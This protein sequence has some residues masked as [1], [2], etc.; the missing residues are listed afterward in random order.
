MSISL[1]KEKL[2]EVLKGASLAGST[3]EK[4]SF[5]GVEYDSREIKGGE[6]FIAL[7]GGANHGHQF[8]KQAFERGASICLVEDSQAAKNSEF[9]ERCVVVEDTLKA[10]WEL[11]SYWRNELA[12]PVLAVTGSVGKTTIKEMTASL[13]LRR[14]Q[15][16]YS[17]KSHNNQTGVPYTICRAARHHRW[18]VLEMGMNHAGE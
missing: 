7:K 11:A 14:E 17:L 10:F 9:P 18:A 15:G 5:A 4:I 8:V 2:I 3:P 16:V 12:I 6:L 13:L 1:S